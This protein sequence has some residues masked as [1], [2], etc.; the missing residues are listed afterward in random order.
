MNSKDIKIYDINSCP[1]IRKIIFYMFILM[2][3]SRYNIF[4]HYASNNNELNQELN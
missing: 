2:L 1:K 3:H 4:L